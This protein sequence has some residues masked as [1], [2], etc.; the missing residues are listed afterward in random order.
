[1]KIGDYLGG[2]GLFFLGKSFRDWNDEQIEKWESIR[3]GYV[4]RREKEILMSLM[5]ESSNTLDLACGTGRFLSKDMVGLDFAKPMLKK[6][7]TIC[8]SLVLADVRYLPFR[9][10]SF[11]TVFSCRLIHNLESES[12]FFFLLKEMKRVSSDTIIFDV[13]HKKSIPAAL[14]RILRIK[15][16]PTDPEEIV[17]QCKKLDL[18]ITSIIPCFSLPSFVYSF[19][20]P[21]I[22]AV[23]DKLPFYN[24]SFWKIKKAGGD[25]P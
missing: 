13:L 4:H 2:V 17:S 3:L 22:C 1:M 20:P 15:I 18:K 8:K 23:V 12:L 14:S 10:N 25:K 9:P 16:Y 6:A 7:A 11:E 21:R 19:L 24:R 5:G